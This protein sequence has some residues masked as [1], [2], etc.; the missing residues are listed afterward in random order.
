MLKD[1][2]IDK[3]IYNIQALL[4][5]IRKQLEKVWGIDTA[6][7]GVSNNDLLFRPSAGQCF[8]T[9]W[10][11]KTKIEKNSSFTEVVIKRG[12]LICDSKILILDHCW[13][14]AKYNDISVLIDITQDQATSNDIYVSVKSTK[15]KNYLYIDERKYH[16]LS[17]VNGEALSRIDRLLKKM[18]TNLCLTCQK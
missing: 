1:K 5:P 15:L 16:C 10:F 13:V 11:L 17:E 6:Y 18:E 3:S 8:V 9:S 7:P 12:K 4:L 14:E 2:I